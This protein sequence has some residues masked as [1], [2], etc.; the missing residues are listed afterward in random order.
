M[1]ELVVLAVVLVLAA[2]VLV[3]G[4]LLNVDMT[5]ELLVFKVALSILF[6]ICVKPSVNLDFIGL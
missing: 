3:F 5:N 4:L 1:L 2:L 6:L